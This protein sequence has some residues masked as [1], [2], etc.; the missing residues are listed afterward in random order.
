MN[1]GPFT[2]E[3]KRGREIVVSGRKWRE[4]GRS[5]LESMGAERDGPLGKEEVRGWTKS[6]ETPPNIASF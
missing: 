6:R 4:R 5:F 3:D 2:R 1:W